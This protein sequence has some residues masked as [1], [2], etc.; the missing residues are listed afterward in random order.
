MEVIDNVISRDELNIIQEN[1]LSSAFPWYFNTHTI[2]DDTPCGLNDFQFTHVFY[3][4]ANGYGY[5]QSDYFE[6][7]KPIINKLKCRF[8]MRAKANMRTVAPEK[9]MIAGWHTD[10]ETNN[11]QTA[12]F[13]VN[14]N[15]GYTMFKESGKKVESVENRLVVFPTELEHCGVSCTD[16]KQRV[17]INFNFL[18][19]EL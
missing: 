2:D 1:M 15:N 19:Q 3:V 14:S 16:N 4:D 17:V 12:I 11:T 18:G 7:I 5:P 13:Y 9:D 8:L 10:Y 6:I